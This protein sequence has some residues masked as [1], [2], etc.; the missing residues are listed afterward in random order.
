MYFVLPKVFYIYVKKQ[1]VLT[2]HFSDLFH[3][4]FYKTKRTIYTQYTFVYSK[5]RIALVRISFILLMYSTC[6]STE[7]MCLFQLEKLK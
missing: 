3:E 7:Q 5:K 4:N 1:V 6:I 2:H